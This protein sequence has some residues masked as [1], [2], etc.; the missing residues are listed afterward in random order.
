MLAIKY[1]IVFLFVISIIDIYFIFSKQNFY[2]K[3]FLSEEIISRASSM[4]MKL[5]KMLYVGDT[6]VN[7]LFFQYTYRS[8]SHLIRAVHYYGLNNKA[9]E[10]IDGVNILKKFSVQELKKD[11]VISELA[12]LSIK[13]KEIFCETTTLILYTYFEC[14]TKIKIFHNI[15]KL[16]FKIANKELKKRFRNIIDKN[17]KKIPEKIKEE[18]NAIKTLDEHSSLETIQSLGKD[19]CYA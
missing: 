7:S 1:I 15:F 11:N 19:F 2:K 5:M 17:E 10:A 8:L 3:H 12:T 9:L 13:Q 6:N 16:L 4:R 14:N 18:Y